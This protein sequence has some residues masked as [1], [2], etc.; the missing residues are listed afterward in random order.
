M[1]VEYFPFAYRKS[2]YDI[3]YEKLYNDGYK[4]LFFDL[5]NTLVHHGDPAD[6]RITEFF[7]KIHKLGFKTVIIS[8]N[9]EKRTAPFAA[10]V[11]SEYICDASKPSPMPFLRALEISGTE[12]SEAIVIGDQIF[13]DILGANRSGIASV[14]VKYIKAPGEKWTGFRRKLE[15][16]ILFIAKLTKHSN[17]LGEI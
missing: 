5:D 6:E 1:L 16:L 8:D 2:V 13:K 9:E 15:F 3:N 4:A 14:M 10:A 12:K 11:G 7:E 17:R